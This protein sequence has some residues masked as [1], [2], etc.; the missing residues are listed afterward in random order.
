MTSSLFREKRSIV[1]CANASIPRA[2]CGFNTSERQAPCISKREILS[3]FWILDGN[4][5]I[6]Y[7]GGGKQN[8]LVRTNHPTSW[9]ENW[10]R[11]FNSV[12]IEWMCEVRALF[13]LIWI[14]LTVPLQNTFNLLR[15]VEE[16]RF[17]QTQSKLCKT[18]AV[19]LYLK[20]IS[21]KRQ[22]GLNNNETETNHN[23]PPSNL[24]CCLPSS[25]MFWKRSLAV[26]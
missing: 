8:W 7:L 20:V 9:I 4:H 18:F 23:R 19:R 22:H 26:I 15:V 24:F 16:R 10:L 13:D 14:M 1:E 5:I 3:A 11:L 12:S 2:F 25:I 21:W 17:L 6:I